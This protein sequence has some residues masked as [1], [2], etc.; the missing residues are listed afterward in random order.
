MR[1]CLAFLVLLS[2]VTLSWCSDYWIDVDI[3]SDSNSGLSPETAW[4][5]ITYAVSMVS[6]N[7]SDPAIIHISAGTYSPSTGEIFPLVMVD[8][9][10]LIGAGKGLT[11]IDAEDSDGVIICKDLSLAGFANL[12]ITKGHGDYG[13]GVWSDESTISTN[14]LQFQ[15][16]QI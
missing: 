9:V 10:A 5:T 12:T 3:G 8:Y 2:I 16:Q 4:K 1:F 15:Q 11:I 14:E 6:G 7:D 13:G